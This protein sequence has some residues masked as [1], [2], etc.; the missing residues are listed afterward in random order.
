[1]SIIGEGVS[2]LIG[3]IPSIIQARQ[4]KKL[5]E[6]ADE[7]ESQYQ[8]PEYEIS[9]SMT[10]MVDYARGLTKAGDVPGGQMMRNQLGEATAAGITAMKEMGRGSEAFGGI[11]QLVRGEHESLRDQNIDIQRL[12]QEAQG[13]YLQSLGMQ[14]GEERNKWQWEEADPYMMA[15]HKASQLRTSG[16]EGRMGAFSDMSGV[17]ANFIGGLSDM[18]WQGLVG[19]NSSP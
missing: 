3:L 6:Q 19:R 8:R 1:M 15:A 7:L 9:P 17:G 11:S 13:D 12:T 14:A 10:G 2:S 16:L 4:S 5:M 18:D